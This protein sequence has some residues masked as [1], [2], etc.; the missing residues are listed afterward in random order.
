[1]PR[2]TVLL[3]VKNGEDTIDRAARSTL[4]AMPRDSQLAVF[5]DASTDRT[6]EV[7]ERIGDPRVQVLASAA[8]TGVAS[9][10]NHLLEK[11]DSRYIARM[12]ADDISLPWRFN[13]QKR[14]LDRS[15]GLCFTTVVEWIPASRRLRPN[16]PRRISATAFPYHL[17]LTNPVAHSTMLGERTVVEA[18]GG[19]RQVPAEDYDL[20]MRAQLAGAALSCAAVPGLVYRT[21]DSQVTASTGWRHASWS[22]E[23][24]SQTF[25]DL[26]RTLLGEP[27]LRLNTLLVLPGL[28]QPEFDER[29]DGFR[30]AFLSAV[31]SVGPRDRAALQRKLQA[32]LETVRAQFRARET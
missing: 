12:D 7:L 22:N 17:L 15:G 6:V 27:F 18:V 16:P 1:V 10:L 23:L 9:G 11:T 30:A 14:Q 19:Y 21:H 31:Q 8:V 26:S 5:D 2:L 3:P 4:R 25:Q 13:L 20:W 29:L 24:V 32:R 28:A